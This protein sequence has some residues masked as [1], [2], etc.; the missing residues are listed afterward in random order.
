MERLLA[1]HVAAQLTQAACGIASLPTDPDIKDPAVRA[2]NLMVWETFRIFYA[3]VIKALEDEKDWPAPKISAL[4]LLSGLLAPDKLAS[5]LPLV[6]SLLGSDK[7]KG[8]ID[9]ARG[10]LT[11]PTPALPSGPLPNPGEKK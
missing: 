3:A 11:P 9:L 1:M 8:L 7:A 4:G 5:L 10:L 6:G 2:H